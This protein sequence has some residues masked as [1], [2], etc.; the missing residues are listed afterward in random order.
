MQIKKFKI[1]R[2]DGNIYFQVILAYEKIGN[3]SN[4]IIP[5]NKSIGKKSRNTYI[6]THIHKHMHTHI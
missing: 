5:E 6:H 4:A 3:N 1:L 2:K